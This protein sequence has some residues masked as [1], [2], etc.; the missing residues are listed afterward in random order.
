MTDDNPVLSHWGKPRSRRRNRPRA[1]KPRV[2][3]L[4]H[5]SHHG[6][7][8]VPLGWHHRRDCSTGDRSRRYRHRRRR[9]PRRRPLRCRRCSP[10]IGE[11]DGPPRHP[12][13]QRRHHPRRDDGQDEVLG[14]ARQRHRHPGRRLAQQL[15]RHGVR[16]TPDGGTTQRVGG[17][18]TSSSGAVHYAFGPALRG[19]QSRHR[20]DGRR[21][22]V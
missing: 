21:H 17:V 3:G 5:R 1:G 22:G 20:Q 6:F 8:R 11:V 16:R 9:G 15:R 4:C 12:G 18:F 13:E 2:H 10:R 19:A 14:G 7:H